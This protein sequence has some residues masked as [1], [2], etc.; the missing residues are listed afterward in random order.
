MKKSIALAIVCALFATA[1]FAAPKYTMGLIQLVEQP[2]LDEIRIAMLDELVKLGYGPD[3]LEITYQN[4][5]NSPSLV[6][7][8]CQKFVSRNV[9]VIV[10][11]A[12]TA[13]QGAAAATDTIPIVFSAVSDPLSAGV[14]KNLAKPE[15]NVTG[16]S[17]AINPADTLDLADELTPGIKHYGIIYSTAETNSAHTAHVAEEEMTRRGLTYQEAIISSGAEVPAAITSLVGQVDAVFIPNDNTTA[18]AMPLLSQIAIENKLPVYAAV[19]SLV[20]DGAIGTRGISYTELGQ[21]TAK[22]IIRILNGAK[23]EDTPVEVMRGAL[24][25]INKNTADALGIDVSKY[26]K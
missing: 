10:P 7:T 26:V 12:T 6:N 15:A 1:S 25:V 18:T 22:M 19:D 16:V 11:I 24:V 5:Q 17:N 13:A 8:I 23:I 4:A 2:S 14:V 20:R 3:V 21:N 9:D